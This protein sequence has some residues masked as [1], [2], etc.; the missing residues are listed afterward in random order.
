MF[1]PDTW[2]E[3]CFEILVHIKVKKTNKQTNK[4]NKL[5]FQSNGWLLASA[6]VLSG[7]GW[8]SQETAISDSCQQSLF[9]NHNNVWVWWLYVGWIPRWGN[10]C[11]AFPSVSVQH[12]VSIFPPISI[13]FPLLRRT[14]EQGVVAHAF[15]PS[16]REAEAG[17]FLKSRPACSTKWV[18]GQPGLYRETLSRKNQNKQT[19]KQ[20]KKTKNK[21]RPKHPHF[22]L[23]SSW[24]SSGLW[25]VS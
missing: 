6:S 21:K 4:Q 5:K 12:F 24:A 1:W 25:I 16:T 2:N 7:S 15:N 23:T 14:K 22:G 3:I 20:T 13:L 18:P 17:R 9:D 10:L 19:N 11:M 8:A